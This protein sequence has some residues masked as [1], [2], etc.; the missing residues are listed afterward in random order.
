MSRRWN[1]SDLVDALLERLTHRGLRPGE[2]A[3][4]AIAAGDLELEVTIKVRRMVA[5]DQQAAYR[6]FAL[7]EIERPDR[8]SVRCCRRVTRRGAFSYETDC[9]KRVVA[10]VLLRPWSTEQTPSVHLVCTAHRESHGFKP[11]A[12]VAI[13]DFPPARLDAAKRKADAR[14]EKWRAEERAKERGAEGVVE[15]FESVRRWSIPVDEL[16]IARRQLGGRR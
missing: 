5:A 12:V 8:M 6:E 11:E 9:S 3:T 2:T 13:V 7:A 16:A 15:L 4:G 1:D 10:A 14:C